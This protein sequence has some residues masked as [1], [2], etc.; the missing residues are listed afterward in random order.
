M[1][2]H[3][4]SAGEWQGARLGWT[5]LGWAVRQ[6]DGSL[7]RFR[8]C[9]PD[10][11]SVC[12]IVRYRDTDG[13]VID[14]RRNAAGRLERI[15]A[16][17][18]RWIAF[19]YDDGNR[20]V[21]AFASTGREVRYEYD[22]R[23]RLALVKSGEE[24][25]HRYTYTDQDEM[26]TMVEP[27]INIENW[28]DGGRC[29]RQ[30]NRFADGS[31]PFVFDFSYT[32]DGSE[33]VRTESRRS[34][35]SWTHYTFDRSGFTTSETW[36]RTGLDPATFVYDRDPV[37]NAVTSLSL[38][39]PDRTGRP[40]RHSSLVGPGREDWIKWDLARTHCAWPGLRWRAAE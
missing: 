21:R 6:T 25:T 39:C 17:R 30:V 2:Q 32:L 24:T 7:A 31:E 3:R 13:H 27:G 4:S 5:G 34:D 15:E 40:L 8:G 37:T 28:Y 16:G 33:V 18:D 23:G 9:G 35:G 38:T 29:V 22:E 14:Y 10:E 19:D 12:S 26:A 1:Y 20:V 36:G 11:R